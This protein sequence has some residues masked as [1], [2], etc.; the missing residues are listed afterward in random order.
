MFDTIIAIIQL[1]L[2]SIVLGLLTK[3]LWCERRFRDWSYYLACV[4]VMFGWM[5]VFGVFVAAITY[6]P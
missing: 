4:F 5:V 1:V 2:M 6:T 3:V